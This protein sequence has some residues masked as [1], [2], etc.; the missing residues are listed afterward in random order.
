MC[1]LEPRGL[2]LVSSWI[3]EVSRQWQQQ[4]ESFKDY[5]ALRSS[6]GGRNT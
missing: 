2:D 1:T 3:G 4:L 5:V 6:G